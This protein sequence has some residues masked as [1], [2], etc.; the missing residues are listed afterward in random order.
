[1][2][3]DA[4]Q[5]LKDLQAALV[6]GRGVLDI[7]FCFARGKVVPMS[8]TQQDA[9][10]ALEAYRQGKFHPLPPAGDSVKNK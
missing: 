5:Q 1:M 3:M 9:A 6:G 2:V 4:R 7:K 10:S 8:H